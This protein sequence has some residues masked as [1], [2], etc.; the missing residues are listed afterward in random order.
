MVV[1]NA[2]IITVLFR[3]TRSC[4][5]LKFD[6]ILMARGVSATED[7]LER[8]QRTMTEHCESKPF[9]QQYHLIKLF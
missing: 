4:G 6:R 3:Q 7:L 1:S 5:K 9:I 8:S 2:G